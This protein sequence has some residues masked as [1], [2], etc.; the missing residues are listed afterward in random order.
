MPC[1]DISD[2]IKQNSYNRK[3]CKAWFAM[4]LG[5]QAQAFSLICDTQGSTVD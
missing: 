2:V 3:K 1:L 4:G 5:K